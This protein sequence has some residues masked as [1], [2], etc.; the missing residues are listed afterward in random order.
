MS[1]HSHLKAVAGVSILF[2]G[3]CMLVMALAMFG[4]ISFEMALLMLVAV[5]GLHVGFG[6]LFIVYRFINRLE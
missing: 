6:V 5:V 4:I 1:R 2:T 3:L